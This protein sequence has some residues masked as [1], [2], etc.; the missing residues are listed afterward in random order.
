MFFNARR[1]IIP[2]LCSERMASL[3]ATPREIGKHSSS[4]FSSS[5]RLI[6][7]Q[8]PPPKLHC[9]NFSPGLIHHISTDIM[10]FTIGAPHDRYWAL[11]R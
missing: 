4:C 9:R 2:F 5:L 8:P 11:I 3:A 10:T 1:I 6:S 7:L